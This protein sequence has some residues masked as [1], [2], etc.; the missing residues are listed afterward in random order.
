MRFNTELYNKAFPKVETPAPS[1]V[2]TYENRVVDEAPQEEPVK[3]DS[4]IEQKPEPVK[5]E[6][7]GSSGTNE[8]DNE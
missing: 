4:K 7:D 6:E 1:E 3:V 5:E 2:I 8:P